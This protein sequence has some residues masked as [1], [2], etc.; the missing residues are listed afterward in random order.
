MTPGALSALLTDSSVDDLYEFRMLL[1]TEAA[2]KA[3]ERATDADRQAI[4]AAL[5]RY[6]RAAAGD[7]EPYLCDVEFHR[8]I[9]AAAHNSAYASAL[10]AVADT[11][12]NI[13]QATDAVPGAVEE[14]VAEHRNI[15]HYVV[16]GSHEA[17]RAAM[18][19]H[20][21]TARRT[22]AAARRLQVVPAT[23]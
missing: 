15:A 16:E 18:A 17:A 14:A 19:M 9:V 7:G 11:L 1:E 21:L 13:R 8:V 6:E 5:H 3:A 20:M 4:S 22:L 23:R 10:D 12:V 2:A